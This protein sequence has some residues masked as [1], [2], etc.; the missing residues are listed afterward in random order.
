VVLAFDVGPGDLG[1]GDE[2]AGPVSRGVRALQYAARRS[3]VI[4]R[5]GPNEFA[6]LA[7]GTDASGARRLAERLTRSL[8][9]AAPG[10]GAGAEQALHVR[11][12]YEAVANV[13]YAPI[14]P[15]ELLVRAAAAVRAAP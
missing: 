15:V 1:A 4:G 7:P 9:S 12:G 6:V 8:E 14:E 13:G 11:S 3:D 10:R 2:L 5:L